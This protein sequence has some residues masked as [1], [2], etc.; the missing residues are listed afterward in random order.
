MKL[1]L[2][3][4][5][6]PCAVKCAEALRKEADTALFWFNPNIHPFTE[7][8]NRLASVKLLA[9]N[10]N[11]PLIIHGTYGLR[12]FL[13]AVQENINERCGVCYE[14]RL[15]ETAKFAAENGFDC[16]STTL[17]ISPYQNHELIKQTAEAAA[18]KFG[19]PFLYRD[20][21][22]LF[23]DGQKAARE[24]GFYMQKYCGCIFSEEE[25]YCQNK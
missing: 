11:I 20:F 1:L 19:V 12:G 14:T 24:A 15:Y 3:V 13:T 7:Y 9:E 17:L 25:R 6:A 10:E 16:F 18:K 2:H 21:R 23:R 8:E 5:C 4:C 22:T